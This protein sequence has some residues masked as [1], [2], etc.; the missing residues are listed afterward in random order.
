M[1]TILSKTRTRIILALGGLV[2]GALAL[3]VPVAAAGGPLIDGGGRSDCAC[4]N[5]GDGTL[6]AEETADLLYM[7]EEEK[8]ARDVY[9]ALYD[10]WGVPLFQNIAA[11]EQSHMDSVLGVIDGHGLVDPVGAN[12]LGVFVNPDLQALY[13]QLVAQ[14][15]QSLEAALRVGAAIE[16]IDIADLDTALAS[17]VQADLTQVFQQL[18]AGSS[19]HLRAFVRTLA[20]QDGSA[21]APQYLDQAVF[22]AI[23]AGSAG[24]GR[25]G[26]A[27]GSGGGRAGGMG[28]GRGRGG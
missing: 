1:N 21:Y 16:E 14:G 27:Q 20:Q 6:N 12:A 8:L 22:E 4:T 10:I 5:P 2:F 24:Q 13:N 11:S 23:M 28:S 26:A 19:N 17:A 7:R 3:V 15:S 25:G 9:L 18:R